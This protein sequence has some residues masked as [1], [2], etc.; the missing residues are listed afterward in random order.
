MSNLKAIILA[1]GKGTRMNSDLP[2]VLHKIYDKSMIDYI[3]NACT[4]AGYN[5]IY[6]IVGHKAET[7][8]EHV[9]YDNVTFCLQKEQLGTGHAVMQASDY[10]QDN[11]IIFVINGVISYTLLFNSFIN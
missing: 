6:I 8:I 9:K 10:I 7:I 1:G 2:K 5:D 3:Y 11:D 4:G